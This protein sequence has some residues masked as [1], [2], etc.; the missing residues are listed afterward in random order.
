MRATLPILAITAI[1]AG[2]VLT[3]MKPHSL[4]A[5]P[6]APSAS[7]TA[8][9]SGQVVGD[10]TAAAELFRR[11]L[12]ALE[13]H[14]SVTARVRYQIDLL[15]Q[16]TTGHG[17]YLQGPVQEQLY[18]L[19]LLLRI[20]GEPASLLQ[21]CDGKT[22]WIRRQLLKDPTLVRVDVPSTLYALAMRRQDAGLG[23][24]SRTPGI[25]GLPR[26]LRE[27]DGAFVFNSVRSTSLGNPPSWPVWAIEGKW[28]PERAAE[29]LSYRGDIINDQ[30]EINL[31]RLPEHLPDRIT[32]YL[33][34]DDLFPYRLDYHRTQTDKD[35][36]PT[37]EI[38]SLLSM[39]LIEVTFDAEV[40]RRQFIY[41]PGDMPVVDHTEAYQQ[42]L[43]ATNAE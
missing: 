43:H 28:R 39:E 9:A 36:N 37:G 21:V 10:A 18:R 20:G 23:P 5:K 7:S 12:A 3:L 27:L 41:H 1:G 16:Q 32:V 31:K 40:D 4:L 33:G 2:L 19:D 8:I 13:T 17:R 25:G 38:K 24:F 34:Q 15:G 6:Q 14:R 11:A 30:G 22:I 26:T 42:H 29:L 35:G